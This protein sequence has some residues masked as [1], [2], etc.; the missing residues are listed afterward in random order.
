[1][2]FDEFKK[3][4]K[5]LKDID[6]ASHDFERTPIKQEPITSNTHQPTDITFILQDNLN[7]RHTTFNHD[8]FQRPQ[9]RQKDVK[10]LKRAKLPIQASLDLHGKTVDEARSI[11][12]KALVNWYKQS[13]VCV[14]IVHGKGTGKLKNQL[15]HWLKQV[16][17]ILSFETCPS[18][19]GGSGALLVLLKKNRELS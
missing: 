15:P 18:R 11:L 17:F 4:V 16:P 5:P 7:L 10:A 3:S 2:G 9:A 14:H 1:M 6:K 8:S 13:I 19:L 12:S